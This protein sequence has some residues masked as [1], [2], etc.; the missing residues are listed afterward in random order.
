MEQIELAPAGKILNEAIFMR[1]SLDLRKP[2]SAMLMLFRYALAAMLSCALAA[3][4]S[5][6]ES[7]D[8]KEFVKEAF[9][10]KIDEVKSGIYCRAFSCQFEVDTFYATETDPKTYALSTSGWLEGTIPGL[11]G[12]ARRTMGLT[13]SYTRGTCIVK[14]LK[15]IFDATTNNNGWGAS[16]IE[17]VFKRIDIPAIVVLSPEDCKKVDTFIFTAS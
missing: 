17:A 11:K 5:A 7:K 9:K 6:V 13:G 1:V 10:A 4:S 12:S 8:I 2:V 3:P 15:P 16:K 14:D